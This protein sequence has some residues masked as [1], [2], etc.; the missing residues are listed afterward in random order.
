MTI[1][2]IF[3]N[4][5]IF[6]PFILSLILILSGYI[7]GLIFEKIV[8]IKLKKIAEAAK[9]EWADILI[10]SIRGI[11]IL[12]FIIVG[13]YSAIFTLPVNLKPLLNIEKTLLIIFMFLATIVISRAAVGFV[14]IY[15]YRVQ[16]IFPSNSIFV[17]LTRFIVFTTGAL[18]IFQMLG[19][20]IAPILTALGVGGLAVA[21]ALQDTLSNLFAG[22][23]II[24]SKKIN[25]GDY[26]KL[27]SGEEGYVMDIT[28][29]NTII[30]TFQNNLII[31]PNSKLASA[32]IT[33]YHLPEREISVLIPIK[34][35]YDTD[36]DKLESVTIEAA[37]EVMREIQGGVPEF[38]PFMRY[39]NLSDFNI[40]FNIILR[41]KEFS[42]QSLIKHEFI[43]K[44]KNKYD[45][46][47]I[48][49]AF[50]IRDLFE[51]EIN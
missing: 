39:N 50:P 32:A 45:Q 23:N 35:S 17:N 15:I 22:L 8:L 44:L 10:G 48:I 40:S 7:L 2:E 51:K 41:V 49:T 31:I 1:K 46:E 19:I 21:L 24:F 11:T 16:D 9:W 27:N 33:N 36:L 47:G 37:K 28:W 4:Y 34:A 26:I 43:R 12:C 20:S 38:E 14:K 6:K 42:D 29:R 13:I 25:P 18:V 5:L 30:K 3:I